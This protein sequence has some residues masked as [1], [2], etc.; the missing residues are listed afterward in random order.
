MKDAFSGL[1]VKPEIMRAVV[2]VRSNLCGRPAIQTRLLHARLA[3]P[4]VGWKHLG[5]KVVEAQL[6]FAFFGLKVMEVYL[7][8]IADMLAQFDEV[9][10]KHEQAGCFGRKAF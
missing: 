3:Y 5:V 10:G 2:L 4:V 6:T 8:G 1:I 7:T 9:R